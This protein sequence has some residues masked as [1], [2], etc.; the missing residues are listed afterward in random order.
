M[1]SAYSVWS[2]DWMKTTCVGPSPGRST[3]ATDGDAVTIA[4]AWNFHLTRSPVTFAAVICVS[5][6]LK[7]SRCGPPA[8]VGHS[9]AAAADATRRP[10]RTVARAC[11]RAFM[12]DTPRRPY[13]AP[14]RCVDKNRSSEILVDHRRTG[15]VQAPMT[16]IG[17]I[18]PV[19]FLLWLAV[20]LAPSGGARAYDVV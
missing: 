13:H 1:R 18:R 9:P 15:V 7:K 16:P 2:Q 6:G 19:V 14:E 10:A 4:P 17:R 20:L 5:A 8:K 11:G 12:K 3:T